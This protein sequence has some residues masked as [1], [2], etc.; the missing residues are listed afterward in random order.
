MEAQQPCMDTFHSVWLFSAC[1]LS[2]HTLQ[3]CVIKLL[4]EQQNL[5]S[6][7]QTNVYMRNICVHACCTSTDPSLQHNASLTRGLHRAAASL[8]GIAV[9]EN[10]LVLHFRGLAQVF[11]GQHLLGFAG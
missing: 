9:P 5:A 8:Q 6:M 2:S 11:V 3:T 4:T 7:L 1:A 10:A